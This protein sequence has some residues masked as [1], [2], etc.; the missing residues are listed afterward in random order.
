MAANI[1][2]FDIQEGI[3]DAW[4]HLTK[5]RERAALTLKQNFL[6]TW[7]IVKVPLWMR[8]MDLKALGFSGTTENFLTPSYQL[9]ASDNASCLIGKPFEDSYRPLTN[10]EFLA[11][12][13]AAMAGTAH[14]LVSIG[15]IRN[16]GRRFAS[17]EV[18]GLEKYVA[19]G[20]EFLPYVNAGDGLDKSSE[21]WWNTSA[22]C[23]VCDNTFALEYLNALA[24]GQS[25]KHTKK[26]MERVPGISAAIDR[27]V[28]VHAEFAAAF[29]TLATQIIKPEQA[30][31]IYAGFVAP[32]G[33]TELSTRAVN[34]VDEL[35]SLFARGAGNRGES[36]ADLFS[37]ATDYY[38]H[39]SS[40]KTGANRFQ[41]QFE[42][43]EFGAGQERKGAFWQIV[44]NDDQLGQ[45]E[46]AGAQL[47][48]A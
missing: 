14:Q 36:R 38:S 4:H 24:N 7:E 37:G 19:G 43:S 12:L 29:E 44:T 48:K 30:R 2:T 22:G 32:A 27:A 8:G 47:L 15:T 11:M 9:V 35:T 5:I 28:G 39:V 34:T 26:V 20:R 18:V 31:N 13:E 3:R 25:T 21:L 6:R 46:R 40:G 17:F 42:S 23:V 16:R 41:R 1:E 33:A 10:A 45:T